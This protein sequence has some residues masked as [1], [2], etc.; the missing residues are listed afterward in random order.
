MNSNLLKYK[1]I[2]L[3]I[4]II[5]FIIAVL[6]MV[7]NMKNTNQTVKRSALRIKLLNDT[8]ER[9]SEIY[10]SDTTSQTITS[11]F[12]I[13]SQANLDIVYD[14]ILLSNYKQKKF[15][16]NNSEFKVIQKIHIPKSEN[17]ITTN[18]TLNYNIDNNYINDCMIILKPNYKQNYYIIERFSVISLNSEK[19]IK[20]QQAKKS[21][22]SS[23]KVGEM[24]MCVL[25]NKD[26]ERLSQTQI[27]DLYKGVIFN[28][29][30]EQLEVPIYYRVNN[31][32]SEDIN[33]KKFLNT[34]IFAVKDNTI[35]PI[36]NG[37]LYEKFIVSTEES[38]IIPTQI[39]FN[40]K[41]K[42]KEITFFIVNHPFTRK[43]DFDNY[44]DVTLWD[45]VIHTQNTLL[46]N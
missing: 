14:V 25:E 21:V 10:I 1:N 27:Y 8:K 19:N 38:N 7:N 45:D 5:L 22:I 41:N 46:I 26:I 2:I 20:N 40:H 34:L 12:E 29:N 13:S 11:N 39:N 9:T 33:N 3:A 32:L 42:G 24:T 23:V 28:K 4:I 30:E 43:L 6:F 35:S 31:M 16:I 17:I 36:F 18:I 44:N 15:S 37:S